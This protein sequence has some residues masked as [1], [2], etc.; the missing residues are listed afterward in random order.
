[1]V[2]SFGPETLW[3]ATSVAFR[4]FDL[5][6]TL[7]WAASGARIAARRGFDLVG[8]FVV[9]LVSS[10]GGGLL[11]DALFLQAGPPAVVRTPAYI[12]IVA[13]TTLVT[14][15]FGSHLNKAVPPTFPR[16]A[17]QFADALG[18]GAFAV[19]G[20]R[21]ALAAS[22]HPA[23]AAMVGVVNAVGGQL[24]RSLLLRQTPKIFQP[25][26]YTASAA[27]VGTVVYG[28][29]FVV[30]HVDERL[31]AVAT[32][33]CVAALRWASVHYQLRTRPAYRR[34]R[35]RS[36]RPKAALADQP[37]SRGTPPAK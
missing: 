3:S 18:L 32:I 2:T 7:L 10:C 21:L 26:E 34:R 16:F 12:T 5:G 4:Y 37:F 17:M 31:A 6:A 25:G 11:R 1:M 30:A 9:A 13:A 27:A 24:V 22:I 33:L 15:R 14:W 23:G 35:S 36:L 8:I 28:L 19:V 20:M 29:L